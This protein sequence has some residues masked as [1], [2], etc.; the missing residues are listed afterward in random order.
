MQ[1]F[2]VFFLKILEKH[3]E[4]RDSNCR[5]PIIRSTLFTRNLIGGNVLTTSCCEN[6]TH[7][8]KAS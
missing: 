3:G 8:F 7:R 2:N 4:D 5:I 6:R 1:Y